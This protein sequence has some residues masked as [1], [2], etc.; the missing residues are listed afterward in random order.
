MIG[1][2]YETGVREPVRFETCRLDR[3]VTLR[4]I[5]SERGQV[6]IRGDVAHRRAVNREPGGDF[7]CP[8]RRGALERIAI[9]IGDVCHAANSDAHLWR[10]DEFKSRAR[11]RCGA[12]LSRRNADLDSVGGHRQHRQHLHAHLNGLVHAT[13]T[14]LTLLLR[15]RE[16]H[17]LAVWSGLASARL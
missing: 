9:L 17:V 1:G 6:G 7:V 16:W 11:R 2:E 3:T 14:L 13:A 12:D 15:L 5:R 4:S 8:T 10:A